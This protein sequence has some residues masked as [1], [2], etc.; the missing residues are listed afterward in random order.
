M[1]AN[2][3]MITEFNGALVYDLTPSGAPF[4]AHF[5]HSREEAR[6]I[7]C[8]RM[9]RRTVSAEHLVNYQRRWLLK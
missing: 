5:Q 7:E 3:K 9:L 4:P 6:D 8:D 1:L 2:K